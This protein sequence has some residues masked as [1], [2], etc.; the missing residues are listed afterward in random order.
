ML[1]AVAD[2]VLPARGEP[3]G[4]PRMLD[5][6]LGAAILN[7]IDYP[8]ILLSRSLVPVYANKAAQARLGTAL[9]GQSQPEDRARLADALDAALQRNRRSL[10]TVLL[11]AG[12]TTPTPLAVIPQRD[13]M[14]RPA[15]LLIA[16][17]PQ[18]CPELTLQSYAR[19]MNLTD[20]ETLVLQGLW[21]GQSPEEIARQRGVALSTVRSQLSA[22]RAKTGAKDL[23][24]VTHRIG[25][26]PPLIHALSGKV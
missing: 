9:P 1:D 14:D 12:D 25:M 4:P 7:E 16:A 17:K 6:A 5:A 8:L 10:I 20:R 18:L 21:A 26:L 23:K 13:A 2:E 24:G 22:L 19:A 11:A 15:V 3:A